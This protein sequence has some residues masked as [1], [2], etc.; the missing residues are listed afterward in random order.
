MSRSPTHPA[1]PTTRNGRRVRAVRGF[2][3]I[4]LLLVLV[5]MGV[6]SA[7][8]V[9][10]FANFLAQNRLDTAVTRITADLNYLA[11]QAKHR[12]TAMRIRFNVLNDSYTLEGLPSL[13][14]KSDAYIV[15]LGDEPYGVSLVSASFSGSANLTY[16]GFGKPDSGGTIVLAVGAMTRT[17]TLTG[18]NV[19]EVTIIAQ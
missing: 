16:D 18:S 14:H 13:T 6:T 1:S 4:E 8:A 2:T 12:S 3:L 9:P 7:M 10:R 19:R 17:M 15:Q 5:I 11:S